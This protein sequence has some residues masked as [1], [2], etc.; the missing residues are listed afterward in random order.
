MIILDQLTNNEVK[1][2][3]RQGT[4]YEVVLRDEQTKEVS[5]SNPS[6]YQ[7]GY[8]TAFTLEEQLKE[9]RTYQLTIQDSNENVLYRDKIFVTTQEE[10]FYS[11]HKDEYKIID[12][13]SPSNSKYKIID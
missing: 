13:P 11:V 2:I 8:Y 12:T 1:Y 3:S 6:F 4:P 10:E 7:E 9:N 5:L